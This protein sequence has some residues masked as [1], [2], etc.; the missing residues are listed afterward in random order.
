MFLSN[1]V[2]NTISIIDMKSL[3]VVETFPVP[4]G[5]DDM[6]LK[7]DGSELWVTS[8]W[9]NRVSVIDLQTKKLK[10]SIRVG[11]S[12]HGLYFHDHA[13]RR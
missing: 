6:E 7:S 4:N 9:I 10:H 11:R 12:P 8:R 3:Q 2:D 5:P 13:P 1:R